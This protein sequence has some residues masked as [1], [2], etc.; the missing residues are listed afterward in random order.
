MRTDFV[1]YSVLSP[2]KAAFNIEEITWVG[3]TP[4]NHEPLRK[5]LAE[6]AKAR[7]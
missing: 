5:L 4:T 2:E 3:F 6:I 1:V 7:R